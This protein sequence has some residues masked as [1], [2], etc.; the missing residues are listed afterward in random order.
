M[1]YHFAVTGGGESVEMC[2]SNRV[3]RA[4]ERNQGVRRTA[5]QGSSQRSCG[6]NSA[7]RRPVVSE[8]HVAGVVRSEDGSSLDGREHGSVVSKLVESQ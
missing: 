6:N 1:I 7:G 2:L 4:G 3:K 8:G 5:F